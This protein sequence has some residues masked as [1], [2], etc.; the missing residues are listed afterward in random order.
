ME[1]VSYFKWEILPNET[2]PKDGSGFL[3][4]ILLNF[5][6]YIWRPLEPKQSGILEGFSKVLPNSHFRNDGIKRNWI[7]IFI[8][9][10]ANSM[11]YE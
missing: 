9:F 5:Y 4:F 10:C 7:N 8:N 11:K 1:T 2:R 3:V 6:V